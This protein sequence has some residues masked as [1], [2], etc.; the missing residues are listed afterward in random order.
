MDILYE[1][2]HLRNYMLIRWYT[3][4]AVWP[5][6]GSYYT[7]CALAKLCERKLKIWEMRHVVTQYITAEAS[8][9][10]YIFLPPPSPR[11]PGS[12][13]L[14]SRSSSRGRCVGCLPD[15]VYP[16]LIYRAPERWKQWERVPSQFEILAASE[17]SV[18]QPK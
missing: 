10:K 1:R 6:V 15:L 16:G 17:K 8:L 11:I 7:L 14:F 3:V 4:I 18:H 9:F 2:I 12:Y 13:R 5:N